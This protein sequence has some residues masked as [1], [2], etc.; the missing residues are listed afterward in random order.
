MIFGSERV[1][2]RGKIAEHGVIGTVLSD[3]ALERDDQPHS[4]LA[5]HDHDGWEPIDI[6]PWPTT[7]FATLR[8]G[9][10]K[11]CAL[12]SHGVLCRFAKG[13]ATD[14]AV[15]INSGQAPLMGLSTIADTLFAVGLDYQ[16]YRRVAPSNW[17]DMSV[18]IRK[19]GGDSVGFNAIAGFSVDDLYAVG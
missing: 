2:I 16:V 13:H 10:P 15:F 12:A 18:R 1:F 7:G 9:G 19:L 4:I 3:P 11:F 8:D 17:I 5:I 6:R 14:E